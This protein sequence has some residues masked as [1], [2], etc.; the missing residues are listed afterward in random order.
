[1]HSDF[2]IAKLQPKSD[3]G[4]PHEYVRDHLML[5][6]C[7]RWDWEKTHWTWYS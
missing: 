6:K 5:N 2:F 4:V 7:L 1:L 3:W